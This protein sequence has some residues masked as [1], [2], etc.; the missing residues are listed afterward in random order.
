[1][2]SYGNF[3][4]FLLKAFFGITLVTGSSFLF[5]SILSNHQDDPGF[6]KISNE[7][8]ISNF[9]GFWGA[10]SSSIL[11]VFLGNL[12][13]IVVMFV[14]YMGTVLLIGLKIRRLFIK[15]IL[16]NLSIIFMNLSL[17][18]NQIEIINAGLLSK[19]FL[20]FAN[21]YAP[22]LVNH[23]IYKYSKWTSKIGYY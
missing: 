22:V 23:P 21:Y 17:I 3:K 15:F 13:L 2:F 10:I 20:D 5:I 12:S 18:V 1:M 9:F 7:V 4:L 19:F 16:I 6:G 8:V 11:I 14:F